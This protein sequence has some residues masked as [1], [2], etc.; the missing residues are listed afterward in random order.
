MIC[1]GA[2]EGDSSVRRRN[3]E[4]IAQSAKLSDKTSTSSHDYKKLPGELRNDHHIGSTKYSR[5]RPGGFFVF[6]RTAYFPSTT[7]LMRVVG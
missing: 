1:L 2:I 3:I 6:C 7:N 5:G 4:T